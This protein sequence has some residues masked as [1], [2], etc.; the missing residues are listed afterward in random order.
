[1]VQITGVKTHPKPTPYRFFFCSPL[2][3]ALPKESQRASS[4]DQ[5]ERSCLQIPGEHQKA[6]AAILGFA[7]K[8]TTKERN[9]LKTYFQAPLSKRS[10]F[11]K[12]TVRANS[13]KTPKHASLMNIV[14]SNRSKLKNIQKKQHEYN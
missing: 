12:V 8:K 2:I 14:I 7:Q 3:L 9:G 13:K 1:M 6:C 11:Q 10:C 5:C 4:M